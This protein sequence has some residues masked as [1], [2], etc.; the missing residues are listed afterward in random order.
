[1]SWLLSLGISLGTGIL[2]ALGVG[3]GSLLVL[4]LTAFAGFS[5]EDARLI[6]LLY[7]FPTAGAALL[8]HRKHGLLKKE[9]L[10]PAALAGC[11][12]ALGA[13][14][15]SRLLDPAV[16]RRGYGFLLSGLGLRELFFASDRKGKTSKAK[17]PS[18]NRGPGV[19]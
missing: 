12:A 13:V 9:L 16:L 8:L 3:G 17:N 15:L 18:C 6:S 11:A 4:W 7:F 14:L 19:L 10:L 2:S 1:M 5:Q